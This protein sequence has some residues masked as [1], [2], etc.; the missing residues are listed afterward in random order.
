MF[1]ETGFL[2]NDVT[3]IALSYEN[4]LFF[5]SYYLAAVGFTCM[6]RSALHDFMR[7]NITV[8]GSIPVAYTK[9]WQYTPWIVQHL[10][11]FM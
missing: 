5:Q 10:F 7:V 9:L 6:S 8:C 11:R 4:R 2:E 3:L 1:D